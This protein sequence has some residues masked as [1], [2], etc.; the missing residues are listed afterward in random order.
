MILRNNS[1]QRFLTIAT[2][3]V[4]GIGVGLLG[5]YIITTHWF[6]PYVDKKLIVEPMW[7]TF[8]A[9]G[10]P[11]GGY[12]DVTT[13]WHDV[14]N[15]FST[16]LSSDDPGMRERGIYGFVNFCHTTSI[17]NKLVRHVDDAN[18]EVRLLAVDAL[19]RWGVPD[20]MRLMVTEAKTSSPDIA[21]QLLTRLG[22]I[23]PDGPRQEHGVSL[24]DYIE[25]WEEWLNTNVLYLSYENNGQYLLNKEAQAHKVPVV[26][27][28]L[29][30]PETKEGW[31]QL[32]DSEKSQAILDAAYRRAAINANRAGEGLNAY[33]QDR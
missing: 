5:A 24:T 7:R 21:K 31:D 20:A 15:G 1:M 30:K 17:P 28:S 10:T 8:D 23:C 12:D 16:R 19:A 22:G 27:W 6:L 11:R 4:V 2:V 9:G 25:K 32:T 13:R 26:F 18:P 3:F 14:Y 29:L 33:L